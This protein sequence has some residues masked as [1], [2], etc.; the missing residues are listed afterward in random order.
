[1]KPLGSTLVRTSGVLPVRS[2][3]ASALRRGLWWGVLSL[4][5]GIER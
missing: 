1:M 5:G 2:R 3:A 4:T